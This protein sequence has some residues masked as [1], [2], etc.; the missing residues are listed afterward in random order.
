MRRW[1]LVIALLLSVG[2]NIGLL[3]D[4]AL[5]RPGVAGRKPAEAH[6]APGRVQVLANRLG[7]QG[8][9]RRGFIAQQHQYFAEAAAPRA[10]L[11]NIREEVRTELIRPQ[12]DTARI[13]RLLHEGADVYLQ[14][15]R[16]VV[17]NVLS[18][19]ALLGP[20]EERR[21]VDLISRLPL[22]GGG[23]QVGGIPAPQWSWWGRLLARRRA[24][25]DEGRAPVA[26][27]QTP[28]LLTT[29]P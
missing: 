10:R 19:R 27:H 26:G 7:L 15:E 25:V 23:G 5:N 24:A 9:P 11:Q 12:P 17:S 2:M 1:W 14:L 13:D 22:D 3:I 6:P 21:Y 4:L 29:N 28:P 20:I 18:S 16:S 8:P